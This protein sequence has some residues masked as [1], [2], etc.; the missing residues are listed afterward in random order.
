ML[1]YVDDILIATKSMSEVN[2]LKNL[3]SREFDM[4]DFSTA[5]KIIGMEI[6]RDRDTSRL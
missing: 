4:K 6:R 2:K 5:K 3:L 1:L